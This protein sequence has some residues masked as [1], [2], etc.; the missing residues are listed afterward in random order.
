MT[1]ERPAAAIRPADGEPAGPARQMGRS[2]A[3]GPFGRALIA[4]ADRDESIVGLTADL[5]RYTDMDGFAERFPDRF[6]NV[7]MAEQDLVAVASGMAMA[8]LTPVATTFA[9]FLTRRAHDF[10]V[11]QVAL[12]RR[13]VKLVG[14]VPGITQSFGPSHTSIDDLATMRTVPG[15]VIVDPCDPLEQEQATEAVLDHDGPVYLRKLAGREPPVLDP[16][17]DHF[18]LGRAMRLRDGGDVAIVASSIMVRAA[19]DAAEQLATEGIHASVT[20]I[21]TLKPFDRDAVA[22]L[23]EQAGAVVTA[24]NHSIVGGL[25]SALC[26]VVAS[27]GVKA[28]V[29]AV[30][31]GDV[32]PPFGSVPYVAGVLGMTADS[33]AGAVRSLTR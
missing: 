26:E 29:S 20:N 33:V 2:A 4:A 17:R 28:R 25:Y 22:T 13:N 30:G 16:G 19:L 8:G 24:E 1:S 23:A 31:V 9:A 10:T 11:M 7:G 21:S 18:R 6:L 12:A 5:A 15:L 14:A 27:S 3:V 32:F